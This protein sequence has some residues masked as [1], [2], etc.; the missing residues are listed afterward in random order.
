MDIYNET[1]RNRLF[2]AI[3]TSYRAKQPFRETNRHLIEQ[4]AGSSYGMGK[5]R[6]EIIINLMNQVV[7]AYT[8][9]LVANRPRVLLSTRQE[10]LSY[11]A[12][13]FEVATNNLIEEIGL[14]YTLRQWVLDA[15]FCV[16]IC[17]IHLANAGQVQLE[18][19]VWM[20]P[21]TPFCSN[22]SLDNWV[23]DMS[24]TKWGE[25][26]F[27]GDYYRIP[28]ED[29]ESDVYDQS[30]VKDLI[31]T[32]KY[33]PDG[34]RLQDISRGNECDHDEFEPMVDLMDVWVPRD[35][36]IYTF[37]LDSIHTMRCK[38]DPV[39]VM[40]WD[41]PEM[42]PYHLLGFNDV[43]ENI[44]PSSPASHLASMDKLINNIARKQARRAR[45]A[46]INHLYTA[47]GAQDAIRLQKSG[48][49]QWVM[50]N[51]PDEFKSHATGGVDA[52]SQRFML[53]VMDQYDRM[54]G[55]LPAILGLGASADTVGQE[56]LIH[57]SVS[58]KIAQMQY[59]VVDGAKRI[60][61]DLGYLLW[62]DK[63]KVIPGTL[64][65]EG[66]DGYSADVTW[67][68]EDREG[69]FFDYNFSID[70][71]SMPYES[72]SQK[73]GKVNAAIQ[74]LA[75]AGALQQVVQA[76]GGSV[77]FA[78]L[79]EIYADLLNEPRLNQIIQ[80]TGALPPQEPG[81]QGMEKPGMSPSTTRNYV[82][83]SVPSGGT[84]QSRNLVRQQAWAGASQ[85]TPSQEASLS[86]PAA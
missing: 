18:S 71:H 15:F 1:Q 52:N 39:A 41:G 8:M 17:K 2:K 59:R 5:G 77:N 35:G 45:T 20:D 49:D 56:Q 79:V 3:E 19:N 31:P 33:A 78:K 12:K 55:N 51:S 32:S 60:I 4:Y 69:D 9:S 7:D 28:F 22:V 73:V 40:D 67:T 75:Q 82:R 21:G 76:S 47:A 63:A 11:F 64:P 6:H 57:G 83:R 62:Q 81:M 44:M 85:N 42:G 46:K 27:A 29:L 86:R 14:E 65:I 10:H 70:L 24:A 72:P 30:A 37:A 61:R 23:H 36:K 68:P 53:D 80:F 26:K 50:V 13:Q 54:A 66:A 84:Q 48:D 58:K 25:I 38:G 34:D 74:Q 43:P 16:G